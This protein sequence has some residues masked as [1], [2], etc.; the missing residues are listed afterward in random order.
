MQDT[1][2]MFPNFN[3]TE[4]VTKLVEAV[5]AG[6]GAWFGPAQTDMT[7]STSERGG[8]CDTT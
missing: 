4:P 7:N 8:R 5:R 1:P 6:V 2:S 3:P